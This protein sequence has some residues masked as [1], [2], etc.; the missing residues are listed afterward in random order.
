[1]SKAL[2]F[3]SQCIWCE[4]RTKRGEKVW[5]LKNGKFNQQ[6]RVLISRI[7]GIQS[8]NCP[9]IKLYIMSFLTHSRHEKDSWNVYCHDC[10]IFDLKFSRS[11]RTIYAP[12]RL[13]DEKYVSGSGFCGCDHY[14]PGYDNGAHYDNE[15]QDT[16]NVNNF[17]VDDDDEIEEDLSHSSSDESAISEWSSSEEEDDEGWCSD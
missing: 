16:R 14:D 2:S 9:G 13:M 5:V 7:C 17:I 3:P 10:G 4:C 1:M 15:I 6:L 11:G 12:L 8:I